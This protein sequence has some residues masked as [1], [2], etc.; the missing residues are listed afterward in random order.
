[1]GVSYFAYLQD[2]ISQ[3]GEI[4]PLP[5]LLRIKAQNALAPNY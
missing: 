4:A 1:L 5:E 2:R 3:L